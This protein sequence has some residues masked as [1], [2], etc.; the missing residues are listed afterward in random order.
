[1]TYFG[2]ILKFINTFI[3]FL[4]GK[5]QQIVD[6]MLERFPGLCEAYE[7]CFDVNLED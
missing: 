3:K 4:K 5:I 2:T 1:M 7:D 6:E